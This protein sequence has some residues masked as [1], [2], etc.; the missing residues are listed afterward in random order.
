MPHKKAKL[1]QDRQDEIFRKMS[2]EKKIKLASDFF[3]FA[4]ILNHSQPYHG[5]RKVV[6]KNSA[7][8]R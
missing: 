1:F 3:R 2:A 7:N 5:A 6:K 4:S 8:I